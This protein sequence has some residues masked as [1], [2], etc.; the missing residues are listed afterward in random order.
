MKLMKRYWSYLLSLI[1]VV[2]IA[3]GGCANVPASLSG[4]YPQDTLA[5]VESLRSAIN[6]PDD[7]LE[8]ASA[9]SEA[10]QRINDYAAQYRR[11]SSVQA[12][13]SF[14]TMRTALNALAGHYSTYPNSPLPDSLK[15]RLETEFKRVEAALNRGD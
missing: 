11:E 15:Q 5:V 2:A 10:R 13:S 9:Q 6:L 1:L 3:L 12:L 4:N 7:S 8:Q 14:T